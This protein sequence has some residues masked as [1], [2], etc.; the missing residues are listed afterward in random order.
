MEFSVGCMGLEIEMSVMIRD[1]M[2][3]ECILSDIEVYIVFG[4]WL[5]GYCL[6]FEVDFV[7]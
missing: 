6:F 7:V 3:Y 2:F 1:F 5:F 4:D